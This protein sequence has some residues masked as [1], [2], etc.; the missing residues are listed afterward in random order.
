MLLLSRS[1]RVSTLARQD[2][3]GP[4]AP[5]FVAGPTF[6]IRVGPIGAFDGMGGCRAGTE[7]PVFCD[8]K[9]RRNEFVD[10]FIPLF[11]PTRLSA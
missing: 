7:Y 8:E 2:L 5:F 4:P 6:F 11:G 9:L 1:A 3:R 10:R